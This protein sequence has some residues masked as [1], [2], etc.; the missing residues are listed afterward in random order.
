MT[1]LGI[2]MREAHM[3]EEALTYF[4]NALKIAQ[5]D[6][7]YRLSVLY[8]GSAPRRSGRPQAG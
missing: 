4:D 6:P 8:Q 1:A 2:G 3:N 7:R 5:H